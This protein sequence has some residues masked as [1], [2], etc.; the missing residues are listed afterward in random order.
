MNSGYCRSDILFLK[1][2]EVKIKFSNTACCTSFTT[3][4][5]TELCRYYAH[6]YVTVRN[7]RIPENNLQQYHSNKVG[8]F[9]R[10]ILTLKRSMQS[11]GHA[12]HN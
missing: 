5:N 1:K 7:E 12:M 8:Y 10:C 11:Y 4:N 3:S 2:Q 9:L 6:I